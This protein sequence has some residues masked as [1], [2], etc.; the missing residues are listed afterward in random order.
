[1]FADKQ[2]RRIE[3]CSDL[4]YKSVAGEEGGT[5]FN[6]HDKVRVVRVSAIVELDLQSRFATAAQAVDDRYQAPGKSEAVHGK[7][8]G[9]PFVIYVQVT[10]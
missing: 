3:G 8:Q 1:M 10:K 6:R 2:R 9:L 4:A 5:E 7:A